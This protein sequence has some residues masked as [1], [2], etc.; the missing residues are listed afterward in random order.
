[1]GRVA[2]H[3]TGMTERYARQ[4]RCR[5]ARA[6]SEVESCQGRARNHRQ[7]TR[8]VQHHPQT[9]RSPSEHIGHGR[10]LTIF[11]GPGP[12]VPYLR[13]ML[14]SSMQYRHSKSSVDCSPPPSVVLSFMINSLIV[15]AVPC[16]FGDEST[17]R[18]TRRAVE[19]QDVVAIRTLVVTKRRI[20]WYHPAVCFDVVVGGIHRSRKFFSHVCVLV[21]IPRTAFMRAKV[22]FFTL[23]GFGFRFHCK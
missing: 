23:P 20:F 5:T 13:F 17:L 7:H 16:V 9:S 15:I 11:A 12:A 19:T 10:L 4:Y 3:R 22:P 8:Y 21:G 18:A 6:R 2:S 1:M 14:P